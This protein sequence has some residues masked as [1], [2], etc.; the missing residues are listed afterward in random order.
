MNYKLSIEEINNNK[1][2]TI[3]QYKILNYLKNALKLS[4]YNND[5][6]LYNDDT[7]KLINKEKEIKYYT[8]NKE[9]EKIELSFD[10]N[11]PCYKSDVSKKERIFIVL[12]DYHKIIFSSKKLALMYYEDLSNLCQG[13]TRKK[14]QKILKKIKK[15]E[16]YFSDNSAPL[17]FEFMDIDDYINS[18]K[19]MNNSKVTEKENCLQ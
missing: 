13:S 9:M 1:V 14:Y 6:Y 5:F 3:N 17:S 15:E 2:F 4:V 19:I 8:Y 7:I 11:I 12:Q 16:L 10:N 18:Y